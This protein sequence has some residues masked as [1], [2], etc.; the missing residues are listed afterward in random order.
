[1]SKFEKDSNVLPFGQP[2]SS[3]GNGGG[4]NFG[5]RLARIEERIQHLATTA[6]MKEVLT[7]IEKAKSQFTIIK[8]LLGILVVAL[9][10]IATRF[11][12]FP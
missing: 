4:G 5:E 8:W 3:S 1:M 11:F 12:P 9:V 7:E 10:S 6:E 2:S